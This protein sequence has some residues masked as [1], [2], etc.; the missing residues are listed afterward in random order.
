LADGLHDW[1][2]LAVPLFNDS[3]AFAE[4]LRKSTINFSQCSQIVLDTNRCVDLAALLGAA[5]TGLLSI[6]PPRLTVGD[7]RQPLVGTSAL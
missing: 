5:S 4:Q 3:L 1:S 6:S 7:L 2:R